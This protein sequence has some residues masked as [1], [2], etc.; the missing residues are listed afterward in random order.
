MTTANMIAVVLAAAAQSAPAVPVAAP[1][2][3][4]LEQNWL[5]RPDR[6]D[7]CST[8]SL[9]VTEVA[10]DGTRIVRAVKRASAPEA[11]CFYVYARQM[12]AE[13]GLAARSSRRQ[14]S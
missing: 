13:P 12:A 9:N 4:A 3:Y 2:D 8:P 1:N 6:R 14:N 10:P 11:D 7:A 5:C